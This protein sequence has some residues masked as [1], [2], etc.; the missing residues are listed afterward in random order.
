MAVDI[1]NLKWCGTAYSGI[2]SFDGTAW[3][4]YPLPQGISVRVSSI[5]VDKY[6]TKWIGTW[7]GLL[8]FDGKTW[9]V[10]DTTAGLAN[11]TVNAVAVQGNSDL[12]EQT[13]ASR[14]DGAQ[15]DVYKANS[16][17]E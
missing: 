7:A 11:N 14:F 4:G 9:T 16:S 17:H 8:R 3:Q 15:D 5:A 12:V 13:G 1:N 10:Y 6:D 2:A